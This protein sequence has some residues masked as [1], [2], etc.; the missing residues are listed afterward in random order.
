LIQIRPSC[1]SDLTYVSQLAAN[2]RKA[3][4]LAE[5]GARVREHLGRD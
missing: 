4:H 5:K 2:I 1:T 3:A